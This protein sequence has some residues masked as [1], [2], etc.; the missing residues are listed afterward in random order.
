MSWDFLKSL[1]TSFI[2][3]PNKPTRIHFAIPNVTVEECVSAEVH[4]LQ[5][6]IEPSPRKSAPSRFHVHQLSAR[7]GDPVLL[8][9][10]G[11]RP[12]SLP[13]GGLLLSYNRRSVG[14]SLVD[15]VGAAE[16]EIGFR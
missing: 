12:V 1:G 5:L 15:R 7:V 6:S 4:I 13:R 11:A 16:E 10:L 2:F 14:D 3:S 8:A 9:P